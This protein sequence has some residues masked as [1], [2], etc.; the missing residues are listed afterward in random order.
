MND[1]M[2]DEYSEFHSN[3]PSENDEHD[4]SFQ[5]VFAWLAALSVSIAAWAY[6]A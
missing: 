6:L 1:K 5:V 4:G 2:N 3:T